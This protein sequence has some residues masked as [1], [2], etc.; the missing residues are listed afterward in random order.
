M[1]SLP[2]PFNINPL[3]KDAPTTKIYF[4]IFR[5]FIPLGG[6]TANTKYWGHINWPTPR[7]ENW[8]TPRYENWPTPGLKIGLHFFLRYE[9]WPAK[10]LKLAYTKFNIG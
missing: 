5:S 2:P 1:N 6:A 8:P 10:N 4:H 3:R 9:N 7:V